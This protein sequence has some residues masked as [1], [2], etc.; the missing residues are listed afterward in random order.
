MDNLFHKQRVKRDLLNVATMEGKRIALEEYDFTYSEQD[1]ELLS[2]LWDA[3]KG[4]AEM[5]R[6]MQ[7]PVQEIIVLILDLE[8]RQR[9][10]KRKSCFLTGRMCRK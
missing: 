3:G 1:E 6:E 9:I 10:G 4:I 8:D 5:M 2:E 7:R